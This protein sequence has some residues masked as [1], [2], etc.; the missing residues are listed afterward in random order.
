M[1]VKVAVTVLSASI[2]TLHS[3]VPLQPPPLHPLNS[4]PVAGVAASITEALEL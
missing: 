4:Q 1:R 3:P 2:V